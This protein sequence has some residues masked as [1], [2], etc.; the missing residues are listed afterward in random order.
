[1]KKVMATMLAAATAATML[2]GCGSSNSGSTE[3]K[4]AET[5][6][7]A[8]SGAKAEET[9][10]ADAAAD[11]EKK[12]IYLLI[13]ARGDLSYWD[14]MAD[15]ADRA[16]VDFADQ[17]NVHVIET[18]ADNQANLTAMYEAADKGAD[19]II[20]AGDFIDNMVTVAEEYPEISFLMVNEKMEGYDNVYAI[21]FSTSQA[22]FLAGIAAADVASQGLEGTSGN[23]TV[24]FIGGMDEVTV[25]EEFFIGYI[26]GVK[27][28]DPETTVV[29][30]YVGDWGNPDKGR[31][32]A[33]AQYNDMNADVIF[34]C[35]GGSGNGVHQAASEVGKYVI[36]VDS[37]QSSIAP[38]TVLTS[39]MKRVDNAV[40]EAVQELIDGTLE[41]G[42]K[43]FD[44]AAGGVDIA[45]SQDL[46]SEDVIAAVDEVK[47][48]IISGDVV[49]PDNKAS[50]EEKYGDVYVL[51]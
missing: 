29:Y 6:A 42:V 40:Y 2:S 22:G 50:F 36:G 33:L 10:A 18:T 25:I 34:A 31:T 11:G 46:I 51:D 27:Y 21:D 38:N 23:K 8:E 17:A 4:A 43:T 30:N 5:T 45:P 41:G 44:L 14:S 9:T 19:M 20:T 32:Q 48:K 15:G 28:Y 13:R 24:G 16:A 12:E 47:E 7:A 49:V 1:M 37:D 35:A 3:T 26:Q 39:A